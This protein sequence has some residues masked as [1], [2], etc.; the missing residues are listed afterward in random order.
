MNAADVLKKCMPKCPDPVA[1]GA[2]FDRAFGGVAPKDL[3]MFF[4]QIGHE[5]AD[6][7]Q[8]EESLFYRS[9]DR[10]R[11]VFPRAVASLGDAELQKL[12]RNPEGL[13]NVV[14]SLRNGNGNTLSGDGWRYRGRGPIQITG[15]TNYIALAADT[16]LPVIKDP[17]VLLRDK[18][19]AAMSAVWYWRKHVTDGADLQTVTRQINGPL[20]AGIDDRRAR[21][22]AAVA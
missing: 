5:S 14:Y 3:A 1:W 17:D 16:G 7:T 6:L 18:Y 15:R 4:A 13:A 21:Y 22:L 10:I 20:L 9:A 2:A 11:D 12:V 8:L 19:S